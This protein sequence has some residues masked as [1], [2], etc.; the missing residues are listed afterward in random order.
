M[1]A[2]SP[3]QMKALLKDQSAELAAQIKKDVSAAIMSE[4]GKLID[5]RLEASE[6]KLLAAI[7]ELQKRTETLEASMTPDDT[8]NDQEARS[9]R[10]RRALSAAASRTGATRNDEAN[11]NVI[12][13]LGFPRELMA[14]KL[15]K[16]ASD[17]VDAAMPGWSQRIVVKAFNLEQK[18]SVEFETAYGAHKFL[19]SARDDPPVFEMRTIR[20]RADR[21]VE[22]RYR[23]RVMGELWKGLEARIKNANGRY[24]VGQNGPK[25]K[26]F[27]ADAISEEVWVIFKVETHGSNDINVETVEE[28]C[29]ECQLSLEVARDIVDAAKSIVVGRVRA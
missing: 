8:A 29:T 25:G 18:C 13:F 10:P 16:F 23:N 14:T 17:A 26:V 27:V 5:A 12:W 28:S 2:I 19:D 11:P 3:E 22:A 9:V 4:V 1:A 6:A 24:K 15:K 20:I 21:T 7:G